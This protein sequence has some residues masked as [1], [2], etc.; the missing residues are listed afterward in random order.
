MISN[1]TLK[2][3][4]RLAT[5]MNAMFTPPEYIAGCEVKDVT[6][7]DQ[8]AA[9]NGWVEA[10]V[11]QHNQ[12][13]CRWRGQ[14]N[15]IAVGDY[16]D[17]LYFASYR[18]FVVWGQGGS[19]ALKTFGS[20]VWPKTDK[21]TIDDVEYDS[22]DALETALAAAGP[23][24]VARLGPGTFSVSDTDFALGTSQH[25]VG[26]GI[27][28]SSISDE[29]LLGSG[30]SVADLTLAGPMTA[31]D[32]ANPVEVSRVKLADPDAGA[33]GVAIG[34]QTTGASKL[35]LTDC[36][37][38]PDGT[39]EL[40]ISAGG[41]S[42]IVVDGGT[43]EAGVVSCGATAQVWLDGVRCP[44]G[45][46][47]T[48]T[49][50]NVYGWYIDASGRFRLAEGSAL[51]LQSST[52]GITA[53]TTSIADPG[54]DTLGVTEKAVRDAVDTATGKDR[55]D[56]LFGT[57][58]PANVYYFTRRQFLIDDFP[59]H[60]CGFESPVNPFSFGGSPGSFSLYRPSGSQ[61]AHTLT[62]HWLRLSNTTAAGDHVYVEWSQAT[63]Y[64]TIFIICQPSQQAYTF[65]W[66]GPEIRMWNAATP[67]SPGAS[68]D[69]WAV[70]FNWKPVSFPEHPYRVG[71]W[72]GT[73]TTF[74]H[75]DGTL[76]GSEYPVPFGPM[77][78]RIEFFPTF[79]GVY[80][81]AVEAPA[82]FAVQGTSY[83]TF[84]TEFNTVRFMVPYQNPVNASLL[85]DEI[86]IRDTH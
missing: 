55:L 86:E 16:V 49:P 71:V 46:T 60:I 25:L 38:E 22:L 30:S 5:E 6:D 62:N 84:P 32:L 8:Y 7:K 21:A 51:Y 2:E 81:S 79:H 39:L 78:M 58:K 3:V 40:A 70:R 11:G 24:T 77:R 48:G 29:L 33:T 14:F 26:S 63:A 59:N 36:I 82:E 67:G 68:D 83:S 37:F 1:D 17:V 4:Q 41:T 61:S 20:G 44:N 64:D 57:D 19:A 69:Y 10:V 43:I 65:D 9:D 66:L 34:L 72:W 52:V 31:T 47:F 54:V 35:K 73:G 13:R 53:F 50:G 27:L 18:L 45:L 76:R 15:N 28:A 80:F 85:I 12:Q 75:N 23:G 42:V 56:R 74:A